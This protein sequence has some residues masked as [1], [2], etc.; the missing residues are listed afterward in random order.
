MQKKMLSLLFMVA[1]CQFFQCCFSNQAIA[2]K[3]KVYTPYS[4]YKYQQKILRAEE[5]E[6]YKRSLLPTSGYMTKEEYEELSKDISNEDKVIPPP[7]LPKDIKMKYVPQPTYKLTRYNSP[8]GSPELHLEQRFKY[9]RE[10]N[11]GAITSPNKDILAYPVVY[12]YAVN[13]CTGGDIFVIP[14]DMSL[15][16]VDR[17]LRSNIIKRNPTPILSTDKDIQ[18]KFTF[19]TLTPIDFSADGSKLLAKE[20]I[21]NINDGIWKTN[22]WVYD[23]NTQTARQLPEI[24]DAIK[25]YWM[26]AEGLALDEKRWDIMPL[27]FDADN[28]DRIVVSA[29]GYTGKVPRFLGNW[30]VDSNGQTTMLLSLF[31]ARAK[32]SVNGYKLI[33]DDVVNPQ[34]VYNDEKRKNKIIK[35]KRK[36]AKKAIKKDKKA[37][38]KALKTKLK[39]MKQAENKVEKQYK[40]QQRVSAPTGVD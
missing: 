19:R 25:F 18:E 24:R 1:I 36:E 35:K 37:K 30:S 6:K 11:C 33:Q 39:Q 17:I 16:I 9:D 15:P 31:D 38:K 32:V 26:N 28:P 34:Q 14:L 21:G 23:F 5:V 3:V 27:G 22:A 20:K 13:Q 2:K 12:Y 4:N 29:Y 7:E 8:P 40:Q 10:Q